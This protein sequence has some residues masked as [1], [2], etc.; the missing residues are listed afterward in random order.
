MSSILQPFNIQKIF[1]LV[2]VNGSP[3]PIPDLQTE[4]PAHTPEGHPNRGFISSCFLHLPLEV[5]ERLRTLLNHILD[6]QW[7][8]TGEFDDAPMAALDP[9]VD[10]TLGVYVCQ[11][12]ETVH[13]DLALAVD[14]VRMHI[15]I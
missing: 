11:F 3:I 5:G 4:W 14:C 10:G 9:F 12:C 2:R 13:G 8:R 6:S 1:G 7:W 15:D